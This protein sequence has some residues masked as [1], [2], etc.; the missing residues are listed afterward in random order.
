MRRNVL[1]LTMV[2]WHMV[3]IEEC[4]GNYYQETVVDV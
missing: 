1:P 3:I 2:D 4:T